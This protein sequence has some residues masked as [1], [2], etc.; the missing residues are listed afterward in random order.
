VATTG[1]HA[2]S[3]AGEVKVVTGQTANSL[4]LSQDIG[5]IQAKANAVNVPAGAVDQ[6]LPLLL[7]PDIDE[8]LVVAWHCASP[9]LLSI[10]SG[11]ATP[12]PVVL[13]IQGLSFITLAPGGGVTALSVSN[14]GTDDVE[15]E[16]Y[17][18][19]LRASDDEPDFWYA[20]WPSGRP[21]VRL[22]RR[23]WSPLLR[24][25][26]RCSS[27]LKS[28]SQA[29]PRRRVRPCLLLRAIGLP[30][31]LEPRGTPAA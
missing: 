24:S 15:L 21:S 18:G 4:V 3:I 13:R 6:A 20:L 22:S 2:I 23:G 29:G 8:A 11:A 28:A 17:V 31:S 10:T 9:L 1:T 16:Y 26:L 14:A 12:G 5:G 19:A 25:P 30:L 27:L 7:S